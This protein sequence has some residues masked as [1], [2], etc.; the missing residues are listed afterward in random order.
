MTVQKK[1]W[2]S[3]ADLLSCEGEG[4]TIAMIGAPMAG[5][6]VTPGACDQ[7]PFEFRKALK[8][9]STYDVETAQDLKSL[10]IH[11]A[12]DI[13]LKGLTP[14]ESFDPIFKTFSALTTAYPLSILLGGNNAVTRPGVHALDPSL[15]S[16]GLITFD[17]H[18]DMRDTAHG[19]I[20]GNPVQ[21]LLDDGLAG[22][23]I[24][25]IGIAPFANAA[26]MHET[27]K[28]EGVTVFTMADC[29]RDGIENVLRSAIETIGT[30]CD[31]IY[32]DFDIDVIERGLAPGA[33]GARPGGLSTDEFFKAA[34]SIGACNKVRAVDLTEFDPSFD[35]SDI[36]A[37]V[38][39]R[40]MAE[41]LAGYQKRFD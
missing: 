40:W 37:L 2:L 1:K 3:I 25:Q 11:D 41:L 35:V 6:A 8:R 23:H 38:A 16:V 22:S 4:A 13:D 36:S 28:Q 15:T 30:R 32:V 24:A 14:E 34:R 17:A 12:G 33:P 29:R 21:A 5:G 27:A 26:Y 7:A 9:I 39:G 10:I 31:Q 18:F 20:N 19:L